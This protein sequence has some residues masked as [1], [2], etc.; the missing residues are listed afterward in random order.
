MP[1]SAILMLILVF[2]ALL[3]FWWRGEVLTKALVRALLKLL[4]RVEVV[5]AENMP[6]I[7]EPAVVVVNHVSF[8]D[9]V[10]LATFLPGRPTFAVYRKYAE[11]WWFWPVHKVFDIF[12]VDPTNPMAAKQMVRAVKTGKTLVIFPEGRITVTGALMKVFDGPGM[13]ADK[14]NAPAGVHSQ[15]GIGQQGAATQA[16]GDAAYDQEAHDARM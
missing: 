13:I 6:G 8:L 9:G 11:S 14:A 7:G 10:L 16:D 12:S 15:V 5:G 3:A 1:N 4:Y 2:V